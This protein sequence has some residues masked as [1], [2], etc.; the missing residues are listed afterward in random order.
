MFLDWTQ[1]QRQHS[2]DAAFWTCFRLYYSPV[3]FELIVSGWPRF[4]PLAQGHFS[5]A[6]GRRHA[7]SIRRPRVKQG[8][9]DTLQKTAQPSLIFCFLRIREKE[10]VHLLWQ[11]LRA[12]S[13]GEKSK[14][15]ISKNNCQWKVLEFGK[16]LRLQP[17][18]FLNIYLF[19]LTEG[20]SSRMSRL[21]DVLIPTEKLEFSALMEI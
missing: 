6:D 10:P 16:Q 11:F 15:K 19:L 20:T 5:G 21:T 12:A 3:C 8:S 2:S 1:T 4:R 17:F 13:A 14:K 9:S 18:L 7:A